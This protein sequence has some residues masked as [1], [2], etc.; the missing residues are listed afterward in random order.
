MRGLRE[1]PIGRL[2]IA[3]HAC[4]PGHCPALRPTPS[5][6]RAASRLRNAARTAVPRSPPPPPR[7]RRAPAPWSRPPPWRR[8]RR[9]GAPCRPASSRCGPMNTAP[10]P[11]AVS[12]MSNL[13]FGSGSCG[14]GLRLSAT[15]SAPVKTPSTP[16]IAS[17]ARRVDR[18]DARMRMGRAHHRRIGLAVEIEIV[19][20]AALAGD[21]PRVLLARHRL[22][23][24]AV[25]FVRPS[26][27]VHGVP[28]K[29]D[30]ATRLNSC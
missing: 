6:R 2:G 22:A 13:V 8:P 19:G 17:R 4:R 15:Q 28:L 12:F 7:R 14:I 1:G 11:G 25:E 10:P 30:Y 9:H 23:D 18:D 20:E 21:E 26:G 5:A 24:E 3:E 16:G 29:L 27:V